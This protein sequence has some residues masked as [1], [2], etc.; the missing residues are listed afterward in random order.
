[1]SGLLNMVTRFA[2]GTKTTGRRPTGA[3]HGPVGT[4]RNTGPAPGGANAAGLERTARK[5]LR[6]VR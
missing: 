6:R 2:R 3:G 5:L 4:G 1:M